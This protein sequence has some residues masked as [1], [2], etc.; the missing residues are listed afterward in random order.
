MTVS[1][2]IAT[3]GVVIG[4][5][6]RHGITVYE[7]LSNG[8]WRKMR[9]QGKAYVRFVREERQAIKE[10][11]RLERLQAYEDRLR[12]E[13]EASNVVSSTPYTKERQTPT[14][15]VAGNPAKL[16]DFLN[17]VER[18]RRQAS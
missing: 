12:R 3:E 9:D 5:R 8:T 2:L 6:A 15:R 17:W 4:N 18:Q 13:S 10:T 1:E 7:L 14:L 11:K 16:R